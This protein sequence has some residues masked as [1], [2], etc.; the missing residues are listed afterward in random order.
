MELDQLEIN[1]VKNL[2][3][4]VHVCM[5]TCVHVKNLVYTGLITRC[6][7]EHV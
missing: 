5:C 2:Y 4:D 6:Y 7:V 3:F 1:K